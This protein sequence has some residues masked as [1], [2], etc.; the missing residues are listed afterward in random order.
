MQEKPY[1]YIKFS[2]LQI[3]VSTLTYAECSQ[4]YTVFFYKILHWPTSKQ[5]PH[6]SCYLK[7]TSSSY[8]LSAHKWSECVH[9]CLYVCCVFKDPRACDYVCTWF[10]QSWRR[11][12]LLIY[13]N[14]ISVPFRGSRSNPLYT[15]DEDAYTS[16]AVELHKT[17]NMT[18]SNMHN[19]IFPM[20]VRL[21]WGKDRRV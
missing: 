10:L 18:E 21:W 15:N 1:C 20:R 12:L 2:I 13:D 3:W 4:W 14:A 8:M 11:W 9:V 19:G 7:C 5:W 6:S 17:C 16:H